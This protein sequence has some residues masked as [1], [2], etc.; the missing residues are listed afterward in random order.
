MRYVRKTTGPTGAGAKTLYGERMK[1]RAVPMPAWMW[2][3]CADMG[4]QSG[5]SAAEWVRRTIAVIAENGMPPE[6]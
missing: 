4:T 3:F 2:Q 1:T 5:V 6:K